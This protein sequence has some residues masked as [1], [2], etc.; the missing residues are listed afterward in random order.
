VLGWIERW[1]VNPRRPPT[2]PTGAVWLRGL[3]RTVDLR[4]RRHRVSLGERPPG[5]GPWEIGSVLD[6]DPG[7]GIPLW[8]DGEGWLLTPG[9]APVP[10]RPTPRRALRWAGAPAGWTGFGRRL[11]RARAVVRRATEAARRALAA[12]APEN[13]WTTGSRSDPDGWLFREDGPHR[14]PVLVS[15]HP[16][17]NDQLV[18]R[19]ASEPRELGY[20][21]PV[22]LGYGVAMAPVTGTLARPRIGIPWASRFGLSLTHAEDP[23]REGAA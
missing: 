10:V 13:D 6:T 20:L 12:P 3:V 5:D 21:A 9:D 11:P 23:V 22:L 4:A 16:V 7:G 15:L 17:T 19:D 1:P 8:V 18:T 14:V 2:S